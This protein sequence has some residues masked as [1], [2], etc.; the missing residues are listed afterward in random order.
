MLCKDKWPNVIIKFWK[1]APKVF[2]KVNYDDARNKERMI[3]I[4]KSMKDS[5]KF[6]PSVKEVI[7]NTY[8]HL[9]TLRIVSA[10]EK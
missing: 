2:Q 10:E 6:S 1:V 8:D 4:F 9:L 3:N 5:D 7:Q